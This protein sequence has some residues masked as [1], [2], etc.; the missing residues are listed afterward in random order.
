MYYGTMRKKLVEMFKAERRFRDK[1]KLDDDV[2]IDLTDMNY[3][4][5]P[6]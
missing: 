2:V 1:D 4:V 5:A 3:D 6:I